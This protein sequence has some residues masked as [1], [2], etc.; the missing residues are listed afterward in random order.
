MVKFL[1]LNF[2]HDNLKK[3]I[4]QSLEDLCDNSAFIGGQSIASFESN[5]AE[6][7]GSKYC[8][9][10]G[11]GTD[12]LEIALESLDLPKNSEVLVQAN[13][14][15]ATSEAVTRSGLNVVFVDVDPD[16]LQ[17]CLTDLER[18]ITPNTTAVIV[19]HLY[20]NPV[21]VDEV[22]KICATKKLKIIEDCAQAHGAM[23]KGHKLGHHSDFCCYS[24]YPGKNLGAWGDAGAITTN[25]PD[26][27]LKAR[28]IANHGRV[29]KYEH[30]F[31]GRNSRLDTIQATILDIKLKYLE[32]W[33]DHRIAVAKRYTEELTDVPNIKIPFVSPNNR[34]VY[35]L[36]VILHTQRDALK[37][38]LSNFGIE[39]GIHYPISLD[40]MEAYKHLGKSEPC[41][42]SQQASQNLLSL[43][44]GPHVTID[45]VNY[46]CKIINEFKG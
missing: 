41:L 14:F 9:G 34:H 46:I 21:D 8:L 40:S 11:N 3:D 37:E 35:H 20:G 12:A 6:Y 42:N 18:K 43:P 10:V 2:I 29:K 13:S 26:L 17:I 23:Y 22:N 28:M 27:H 36:Y 32:D 31:E 15:I 4:F 7:C 30:K 25:D 16:T 19:V 39:T 33:T 5:F 45:E 1:D 24:F 38:H 44:M